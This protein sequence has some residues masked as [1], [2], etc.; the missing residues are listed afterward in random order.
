MLITLV[1]GCSFLFEEFL[2]HEVTTSIIPS[3]IAIYTASSPAF[4]S[5][6][7]NPC[8]KGPTYWCAS[9][10]NQRECH[11][12]AYCAKEHSEQHYGNDP[13]TWGPSYWCHNKTTIAQCYAYQHCRS[14][15]NCPCNKGPSYWCHNSTTMKECDTY[16]YCNSPVRHH[17]DKGPS[18]WCES[19][20]N[21]IICG[22]YEVDYCIHIWNQNRSLSE[23]H[24]LD[25]SVASTSTVP[26]RKAIAITSAAP[27]G[28]NKCTWGPA[29]WCADALNAVLCGTVKYCIFKWNQNQSISHAYNLT[30]PLTSSHSARNLGTSSLTAPGE[31]K[32]TWGPAFWCADPKNALL[33]GSVI[34]CNEHGWKTVNFKPL[35][36]DS[37]APG[38]DGSPSIIV[39]RDKCTWGPGFWCSDYNNAVLC[40]TVPFCDKHGWKTTITKPHVGDSS[41]S[42]SI[43]V[44]RD[45]CTWGPGFWCSDY[46][47][48]VL[49]EIN[50]KQRQ[51][52]SCKFKNQEQQY[53]MCTT[54][55]TGLFTDTQQHGNSSRELLQKQ[56]VEDE[57]IKLSDKAAK[58]FI[59]NTV[60][61]CNEHGWKAATTTPP[62]DDF[63]VSPSII[64]GRDKCTW[65]PGFWC[66]D[67]N[68]AVLCQTVPFCDKHGWK[69]TTTKPLV[70]DF[71]AA[72][73]GGSR[74]TILGR[75][76]C[77]WGPG[78]W[79]SGY[80]NAVLCETVAFCD[81]H[82]WKTTTVP[83]MNALPAAAV[84]SVPS[85]IVGK[86][87]CTWGPSFWCAN[88][89]NAVLCGA[90]QYC[91]SKWNKNQST[92][93][94]HNLTSPLRRSHSAR[95]LGNSSQTA[96][97]QDKCTWGPAF[98]C[99]DLKNALLCEAATTTP[100][101][102][103][104]SVSPSIIVGRDKCTWG[105]AFWC[106]DY[107][108]AVLCETVSFCEKHGWKTTTSKPLVKD[109]AASNVGRN[110]WTILG[111]DKCTWGPGF[112]C[113]GYENALLCET[114][115]FCDMHGWKTTTTESPLPAAAI[116]GVPSHIVGQN[117]C[118]WGPS[119][120]C[121]DSKNAILCGT[122][123]Y[124][125]NHPQ[126]PIPPSGDKRRD[127]SKQTETAEDFKLGENPC[128]WGPS[129]WCG[130]VRNALRCGGLQIFKYCYH[131]RRGFRPP[132]LPPGSDR[133]SSSGA[134]FWC[135]NI[136]NAI[137]CGEKAVNY[138]FNR[139]WQRPS[140]QNCQEGPAFWCR[141]PEN[142]IGCSFEAFVHC[143]S[144]GGLQQKNE[145]TTCGSIPPWEI[146]KEP[147][148]AIKCGSTS[149]QYCLDNDWSNNSPVT[150]TVLEPSVDPCL[151]GPAYWC[152]NIRSARRCNAVVYCQVDGQTKRKPFKIGGYHG[153]RG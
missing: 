72:S 40:H 7:Q 81:K 36:D 117:N 97:G 145:I 64:V 34:Y 80:E 109:S 18:F 149:V 79:C 28:K 15:I 43:I 100:P 141:E 107:N 31:N 32:C 95:N 61:Y 13:C 131:R 1:L 3:I 12:E 120:W 152:Q 130:D 83:P 16:S 118:T 111:R 14:H 123:E 125:R 133:C 52:K 92:S 75:D 63:S 65:G 143:Y 5:L 27:P 110:S 113:S 78:F 37:S 114:I 74:S 93:D 22:I 54:S 103:D 23:E 71:A 38:V 42:S 20:H 106:Y 88:S 62:V 66:S 108:N 144:H 96:P 26:P 76:K 19:F 94:S 6:Q 47:N 2:A 147:V 104:S 57:F 49:C 85:H 148:L 102:D 119:F 60:F 46:N 139:N 68:N 77:T 87:N 101:V 4:S 8:I 10:E 56:E 90:V 44:G 112:W 33:C 140:L 30:L 69:T 84:A 51:Y 151:A 21:A 153:L 45:K 134:V 99:S 29:F 9:P 11:A 127:S 25:S 53:S 132:G 58:G 150:E 50:T 137:Q 98:W 89:K 24:R 48:A 41:V 142:A 91:S 121:T 82:G 124:C 17:C 135:S 86:N 73:V 35:L 116:T 138:C 67:Y 129:Y 128:M 136:L 122:V 115:A 70:E 126:K 55:Q 59:D 105:P 146:C 39:G